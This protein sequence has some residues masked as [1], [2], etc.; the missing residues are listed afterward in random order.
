MNHGAQ[1]SRPARGAAV[2]IEDRELIDRYLADRT[3][4]AGREAVEAR[5]VGDAGF[6]AEVE[7]TESLR[8]GLRGL[9]A[10]GGLATTARTRRGF[11]ERPSYAL[12]ASV[13][14]GLL[15]IAAYAM[16]GQLERAR[17]AMVGLQREMAGSR[18]G[19]T[20]RVTVL[21]LVR[22][23]SAG[24]DLVLKAATQ[25]ELLELRLDPGVTLAG[26]Y[27]VRLERVEGA[28]RIQIVVLP[29]VAPSSTGE[30]VVGVNSRLL[31]PGDYE[32]VL[33][34][35]GSG[36]AAMVYRIRVER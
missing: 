33:Q 16:Y 19:A 4:H 30:I 10:S 36:V 24:P 2:S 29:S 3:D 7:L 28:Q 17:E 35:A 32:V 26:A 25:A 20:S 8:A 34:P 1:G 13:A 27:T 14:A 6:R 5:I 18:P 23:R 15:G 31:A 11:W 12:A 9:A 22:T 21:T